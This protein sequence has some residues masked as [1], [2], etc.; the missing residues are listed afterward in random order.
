VVPFNLLKPDDFQTAS[1]RY[2]AAESTHAGACDISRQN[3]RFHTIRLDTTA[4][5]AHRHVIPG[6]RNAGVGAERYVRSR[7]YGKGVRHMNLNFPYS[8]YDAELL[9]LTTDA[10]DAACGKQPY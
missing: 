1:G 10:L 4:K 5:R 2:E 7:L 3:V 9:K 6:T 8:T